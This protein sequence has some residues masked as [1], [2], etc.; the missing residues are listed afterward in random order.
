MNYTFHQL[1]VFLKVAETQSVTKAAEALH[2]TQ[3][4][5]SIQLKKLQEQF[6]IPLTEIVGKRLFITDFGREIQEVAQNIIDQALTIQTKTSA[7]KGQ[8]VGRLKISVVST[9]KYVMPYFLAGYFE[10]HPDVNL[11]MQVTNKYQV[12][13]SLENNQVDF[14]LVSI[15]PDHIQLEHVE[16]LPN[17]LFLI[18][19]SKA[20]Q[21]KEV[22][23]L[24]IWEKF[25]M[26]YR[27]IGSGTRLITERFVQD[28]KIL[29]RRKLE[30]SSNEAVKQ[31]V[32][33]GLGLSLMSIIG[34]KNE[35]KLKQ[36]QIVPAKGLPLQTTWRLVWVKGKRHSPAARSFLSYLEEHKE[37]IIQENFEW[38]LP[39]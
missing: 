21:L 24:N 6:D 26:I 23:G 25:P 17:K 10:K 22:D 18:S 12:V 16:L 31:A 7:F 11:E 15:L 39:Y 37:Q 3:P 29:V 19:S 5:V 4:A 36:L 33:A 2:L 1:Q 20:R 30:L 13:E 14:S 32:L 8:M 9:G 27:E 34:L 28:K 35:I 38:Y